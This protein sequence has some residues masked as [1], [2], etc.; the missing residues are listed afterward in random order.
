MQQFFT[1]LNETTETT[2]WEINEVFESGEN[3]F[4]FGRHGGKGRRSGKNAVTDW[5]FRFKVRD[6]K[7][8]SYTGYV[9]S[10]EIAAA[11]AA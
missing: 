3:V 10:A 1:R 9:D 4:A 5:G 11:L 8:V 6:G 2:L 7:V